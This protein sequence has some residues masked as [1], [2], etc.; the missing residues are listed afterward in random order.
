MIARV[1]AQL[2]N[3]TAN[4]T[5]K[6]GGLSQFFGYSEVGF[7]FYDDTNPYLLDDL[8]TNNYWDDGTKYNTVDANGYDLYMIRIIQKYLSHFSVVIVHLLLPFT[9]KARRV[10]ES[11]FGGIEVLAKN[12]MTLVVHTVGRFSQLVP[13]VGSGDS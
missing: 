13:L 7:A 4:N 5:I 11:T 3:M 12:A 2:F 1:A 8:T 9:L 6:F 10:G